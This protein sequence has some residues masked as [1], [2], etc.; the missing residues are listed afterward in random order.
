VQVVFVAMAAWAVHGERPSPRRSLTVAGVL[1]G[2]ALTSGLARPGAYGSDP[3]LG[4]VC[5]VLAGACYAGFLMTFRTANQSLGPPAGPL[6]DSTIGTV[7]GALLLA[8][9]DPGFAFAPSWPA[10]GWLVSL[11][12]VSQ[13]IGWLLIATALPRLPAL[14]TSILL[15]V[16]PV[17]A[18]AWG[19]FLF[20]ERLSSLQWLGALLVLVGVAS[21]SLGRQKL[22]VRRQV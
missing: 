7:A 12:L 20:E 5:G 6:L 1:A 3:A 13:V 10:H 17:F 21:L 8:P 22:D 11:A 2:I 4:T 19:W 16:Q 9:L 14:E 18:V 15:L